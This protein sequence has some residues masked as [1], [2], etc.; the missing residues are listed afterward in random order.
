MTTLF[1]TETMLYLS[2]SFLVGMLIVELVPS[3]MKPSIHIKRSWISYAV[4]GVMLFSFAPLI[5]L[6]LRISD[7]L[8]FLEGLW[9]V[10]TKF[11][12]GQA[13]LA[14]LC[15]A[16]LFFVLLF[17]SKGEKQGSIAAPALVLAL[18]LIV[19]LGLSSHPQSIAPSLGILYYT[20]H[21]VAI[22]AWVGTLIVVSFLSNNES[23][24][25]AFLKWFT[26][27]AIGCLS[28][29]IISGYLMMT[30]V[31]DI[32]QYPST[33]SINYGQALLIKHLLFIPVFLFACI[34][35]FWVKRK[36]QDPSYQPKTWAKAESVILFFIFTVT[37]V[38]SQ[39]APPN[40]LANTIRIDG[41][42]PLFQSMTGNA[43]IEFVPLT[44][45]WN[46]NTI[47]LC[48]LSVLF[49]VL[50]FLSFAKKAPAAFTFTL[51]LALTFSLY[52]MLMASVS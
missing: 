9:Q 35:G 51:G 30:I 38:M 42:S 37:A 49:I 46:L 40:D 52:I 19:T 41:V 16:I 22:S 5:P 32:G 24:W 12:A 4:A 2:L 44:L 33:W 27:L 45:E 25:S 8:G 15:I 10:L 31:M 21:L 29:T 36:L 6:I 26:P 39:Q 20:M 47:L 50:F 48:G 18:G 28:L 17:Y 3:N 43:M 23:N 7:S 34:N 1:L 13:W 14:T 11:T